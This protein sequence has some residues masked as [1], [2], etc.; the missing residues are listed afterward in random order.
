VS[1][2]L[3]FHEYADIFPLMHSGDLEATATTEGCVLTISPSVHVGYSYITHIEIPG[4]SCTDLAKPVKH[5][6]IEAVVAGLG[7]DISNARWSVKE[8]EP[9]AGPPYA[10]TGKSQS[11]DALV[12]FIGGAGKIKIG[13]AQDPQSRLDTL[14]TGSP[15][16]LKILAVCDGGYERE[17]ELHKRFADTRL[18]GE[19][20]DASSELLD[21]IEG[22]R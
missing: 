8:R 15:V 7:I 13:V 11:P 10:S 6:Y 19:W 5:E 3:T 17:G 14:Q 21:F 20:F 4:G 2:A 22:I 16:P 9:L 18:Y 12:Y 1:E